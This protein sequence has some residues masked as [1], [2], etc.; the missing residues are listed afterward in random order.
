MSTHRLEMDG[1]KTWIL[2]I[3][4][5]PHVGSEAA[6][7]PGVYLLGKDDDCD[8]V[9]HDT[10]LA[11][12]HFQLTL[13]TDKVVLK[14]LATDHPYYID[15]VATDSDSVEVNPYQV[16]S[17]GT[18]FFTL[19]FANETWPPVEL[20]GVER[21]FKHAEE[22]TTKE[23]AEKDDEKPL[24]SSFLPIAVWRRLRHDNSPISRVYLSVGIAL[25]GIGVSLLSVVFTADDIAKDGFKVK[26]AEIND[27]IE[28][29]V[30]DATVRT[31][32]VDGQQ[33]LYIQG[34]TKT[35]EQRDAF[36]EALGKANVTAQTQLYSSA[37]LKLAVSVVLDQFLNPETDSVEVVGVSGFPGKVVL[38]GY[39][40]KRDVWER[41]LA[42]IETDVSGL[43]SYDN[44]VHTM[45]D[46]VHALEKMLADQ[47]LSDKVSINIMENTIYLSVQTL[48]AS[49]Q[50]RLTTLSE[51]FRKHFADQPH[52]AYGEQGESQIKELKLDVGLQS[53]SF[54]ESPYLETQEGK[55]YTIGALI[56]DYVIKEINREFILLSKE[57][58]LGRYYF[59]T[60]VPAT[61]R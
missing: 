21:N 19:G 23:D 47:G 37:R 2:K 61:S 4:T 29:Y 15:G 39:V 34:Y 17:V 16:I 31:V 55:R 32:S 43:Q 38:S 3:L 59:N 7:S 33:M 13:E 10:S 14:V 49:E 11:D 36:M 48:S 60:D 41:V 22:Q 1:D 46:A 35:D 40:E 27:L 18:F 9:L 42:M 56:D 24:P 51:N 30:V 25:I 26:T 53:V 6:L 12:R 58:V 57:G 20:L 54:G 52:L 28:E 44:Q 5:G 8:I 45:D 50:Q